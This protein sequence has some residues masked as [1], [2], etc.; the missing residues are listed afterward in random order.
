[1]H[2]PSL[3]DLTPTDLETAA[4]DNLAIHASWVQQRTLGMRVTNDPQLIVVDCGLPCDTFNLVCRARLSPEIAPER[5][6]ATVDYYASVNRPFS[7]WV[8]P[9]DRP[10]SL[11]NLLL[12]AGLHPMEGELAMAADLDQLLPADLSPGGLQVRRV[13][14]PAH[15]RDFAYTVAANWPPLDPEVVRFYELAAPVLL[16]SDPALWL[17]VGYLDEVPVATSEIAFGGGVVGLYS[18]TTL[19]AYRRRGFGTAMTLQPLLDASASG[20]RTAI[21]QASSEG[22]NVYSRLGFQPF[23]QVTEYKPT[24]L[25][26][27]DFPSPPV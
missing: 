24:A 15:L 16:G 13:C 14:T 27:P 12:A 3:H 18:V 19:P 2:I 23:G 5:V 26:P 6:R 1:V 8:S 20:Y 22:A 10:S 11:G 21:L 4:V 25:F 17:Y 9:G 7:W